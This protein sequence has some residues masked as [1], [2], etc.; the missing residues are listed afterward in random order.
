MYGP[1]EFFANNNQDTHAKNVS[2]KPQPMAQVGQVVYR[3]KDSDLIVFV[4]SRDS[5]SHYLQEP[6]VQNLSEC[7]ESFQIFTNIDSGRGKKGAL[8]EASN[9]MCENELGKGMDHDHMID[10]IL[11]EGKYNG[12][13][14]GLRRKDRMRPSH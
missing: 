1:N 7:M 13:M 2:A 10:M 6:N 9:A 11:R 12:K 3:G 14:D 4:K 8:G 5:A